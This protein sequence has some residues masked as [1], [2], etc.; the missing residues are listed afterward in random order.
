[1]QY[2]KDAPERRQNASDE[3]DGLCPDDYPVHKKYYFSIP[4]IFSDLNAAR[5][6]PLSITKT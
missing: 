5:T 3:P 6:K 1:V 4:P 2:A